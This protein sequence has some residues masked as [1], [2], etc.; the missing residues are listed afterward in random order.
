MPNYSQKDCPGIP[1][2]F[3]KFLQEMTDLGP[4]EQGFQKCRTEWNS[5]SFL[6][7]IR[8]PSKSRG[9]LTVFPAG[10]LK[11]QKCQF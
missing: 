1:A 2:T 11:S 10:P 9:F 6:S 4:V 7:F 3:S 5:G 8:P